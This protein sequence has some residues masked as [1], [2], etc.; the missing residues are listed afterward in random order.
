MSLARYLT[1]PSRDSWGASS[2][3]VSRRL[4]LRVAPASPPAP[5]TMASA[6]SKRG[7]DFT[8]PLGRRPR[9]AG[10]TLL[11]KTDVAPGVD[12]DWKAPFLDGPTCSVRLSVVIA[13]GVRLRE[14][15]G[16]LS[17]PRPGKPGFPYPW[18]PLGGQEDSIASGDVV[19]GSFDS[20]QSRI[21]S[22]PKTT[23]QTLALAIQSRHQRQSILVGPKTN[24]ALAYGFA[25]RTLA[26]RRVACPMARLRHRAGLVVEPTGFAPVS[27]PSVSFSLLRTEVLRATKGLYTES[28][29]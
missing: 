22:G 26:L 14:E 3:G 10:E 12:R 19:V 7:R 2:A 16:E 4:V 21:V 29:P 13:A 28:A 8:P 25:P 23:M 6:G 24:P 18:S 11:T 5:V 9:R 20:C 17:V 1:A 15:S 27:C